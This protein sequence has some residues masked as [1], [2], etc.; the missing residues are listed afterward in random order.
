MRE[1]QSCNI[2]VTEILQGKERERKRKIFEIIITDN[3]LKLMS[4]TKTTNPG[5]SENTNILNV[6][7]KT[8]RKKSEILKKPCKR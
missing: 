1:L 7:K 6:K 3:L 2:S 4:N 8:T 5:S